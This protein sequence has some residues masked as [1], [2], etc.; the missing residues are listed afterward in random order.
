[1]LSVTTSRPP[2]LQ[3]GRLKDC[4]TMEPAGRAIPAH[5]PKPT[6][7]IVP[8]SGSNAPLDSTGQLPLVRTGGQ[9]TASGSSE[10]P[11]PTLIR[12]CVFSGHTSTVKARSNVNVRL[13]VEMVSRTF[14]TG[15][16]GMETRVCQTF[17]QC[18]YVNLLLRITFNALFL[19]NFMTFR[20]TFMQR[21]VIQSESPRNL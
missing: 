3:T 2:S 7:G 8:N 18:V 19:W 21:S 5:R 16:S 9:T 15:D 4:L 17:V 11:H 14:V 10:L 1:M 12:P 13:A 6:L 20:A